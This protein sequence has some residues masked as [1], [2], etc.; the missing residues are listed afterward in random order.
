MLDRKNAPDTGAIDS[1]TFA[2]AEKIT[3][4]NGV[5]LYSINVGNDEVTKLDVYFPAGIKQQKSFCVA[6]ATNALIQ[7]GSKNYSASQLA[8]Q[9]DYYGAFIQ[10]SCGI[11]E[12][13]YTLFTLNKH[14]KSSV[15][16]LQEMLYSASFPQE[17][18]QIYQ[19]GQKQRLLI[20]LQKNSVLARQAFYKSLFGKNHLLG[21]F[22][23]PGD[24]DAL[25]GEQITEFY[26]NS[27]TKHLPVLMLSG[28]V[29]DTVLRNLDFAFSGLSGVAPQPSENLSGEP[30]KARYEFIEKTD[31]LQA[32]IRMGKTTITRNHTD[33]RGLQL[34]NLIL[35]GY[36]GSRL[37]KNIREEK[38]LTYG[39]HSSVEAHK[40]IGVFSI[41]TEVNNKDHALAVEEIQKELDRMCSEFVS[42]QEL[43]KA[44]NYLLGS[45]VRSFD[46]PFAQADRF[47]ILHD[48]D[49]PY[50]YYNGFIQKILSISID[51]IKLLSNK[52]LNKNE[53]LTTVVASSK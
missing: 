19:R 9:F 8:D 30:I 28:K 20:S 17:E 22:A 52:Y 50:S 4:K 11:Q 2:K 44:K 25:R 36:F 42:E 39:I 31:S 33:F 38:G 32:A 16:L 53:M 18:T 14:F 21:M 1:V 37:M 24:Y 43:N 45:F 5:D 23:E 10:N 34:V 41:A 51:D 48:F 13:S 46:G 29:D 15:D 26:Q 47:K 12:A 49:L 27:Y 35:G 7:E 3:F 6:S 40:G